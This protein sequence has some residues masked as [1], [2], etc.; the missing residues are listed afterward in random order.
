MLEVGI[1]QQSQHDIAQSLEASEQSDEPPKQVGGALVIL[2]HVKPHYSR[3]T[4]LFFP[5]FHAERQARMVQWLVQIKTQRCSKE[6]FR[7]AK[8]SSDGA[9]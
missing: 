2:I 5:V 7:A 6:E 4:C 3:L 9:S 8:L 1:S